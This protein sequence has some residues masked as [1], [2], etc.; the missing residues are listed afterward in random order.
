MK[1]LDIF[2]LG[3]EYLYVLSIKTQQIFTWE[4]NS[5]KYNDTLDT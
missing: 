5:R 1:V 3:G 2:K 4:F